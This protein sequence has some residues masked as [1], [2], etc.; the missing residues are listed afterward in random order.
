MPAN[1]EPDHAMLYNIE[2]KGSNLLYFRI[3][4]YLLIRLFKNSA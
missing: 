2:H 3:L 1:I 4:F